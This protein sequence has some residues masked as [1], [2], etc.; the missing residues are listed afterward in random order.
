MESN[1]SRI[2]PKLRTSGNITGNFGKRKV[3]AGSTLSDIGVTSVETVKVTKREDYLKRLYDAMSRTNDPKLRK[4]IHDQ[5]KK[6]LIRT[7]E[8]QR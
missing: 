7:G 8:W 1:L 4:F 3:V 6:E 5:I 2:R